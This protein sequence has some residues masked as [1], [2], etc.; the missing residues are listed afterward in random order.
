MIETVP[1]LTLF[2]ATSDHNDFCKNVSTVWHGENPEQLIQNLLEESITTGTKIER[3]SDHILYAPDMHHIKDTSQ[4][5]PR[6]V[7]DPQELRAC[8]ESI[9]VSLG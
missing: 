5:H 7:Q 1:I 4:T 3:I 8:L 6:Q 2:G 9:Q